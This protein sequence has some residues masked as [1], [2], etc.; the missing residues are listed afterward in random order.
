MH[1]RA[2]ENGDL[3]AVLAITNDAILNST[4]LYDYH[5]RNPDFM[6]NWFESKTRGNYP[7]IGAWVVASHH[8]RGVPRTTTRGL[9]SSLR[10]LSVRYLRGSVGGLASVSMKRT[11]SY[12]PHAA[13][14]PARIPDNG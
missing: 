8:A 10:I 9:V 14:S 7:V 12:G 13:R 5:P 11:R 6:A 4:A 3:E 2:V 1:V